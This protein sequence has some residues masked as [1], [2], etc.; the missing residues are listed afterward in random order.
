MLRTFDDPHEVIKLAGGTAGRQPAVDFGTESNQANAILLRYDQI[1]QA[2][3]HQL[4][5]FEF[6]QM[7]RATAIQHALKLVKH[8]GHDL[9]LLLVLDP[10]EID[11][12]FDQMAQF[13]GLE[14]LPSLST[15]P[16]MI[17]GAYRKAVAN[18]QMQLQACCQQLNAD[19]FCVRTDKSLA[20]S[21]P[22]ILA[23]RSMRGR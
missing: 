5:V 20:Q 2:A 10:D 22:Q 23:T 17:A 9:M 4:R 13:E 15:D 11:F 1:R 14:N 7:A 12:P 18:F 21:L 8:A 6:T 3:G 19:Y 16:L